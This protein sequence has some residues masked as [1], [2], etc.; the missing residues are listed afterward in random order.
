MLRTLAL[1]GISLALSLNPAY[2]GDHGHAQDANAALKGIIRNLTQDNAAFAKTHKA[3][4]YKGF[5]EGQHPRATLVTCSDSRV[6]THAMDKT[7]DGDLFVVRNIGNQLGTAEGSVEYGVHHLHTPLLIFVGHSACGAIQAA[8]GDYAKESAPIK[9]ELDTIQIDKGGDVTAGVQKNVHN[10][11]AA[12]MKKFTAEIKEGKLT[13]IGAVYDF[14]NDLKN[15][16]GKLSIIDLNGETD[17]AKLSKHP[18]LS[19]K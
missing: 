9:R 6:H 14:R 17:A 12:A 1:T 16:Q 7:P 5:T 19:A 13:V 15:G 4:Y 8:S 10:Q 18:L 11:V 3:A 2:A